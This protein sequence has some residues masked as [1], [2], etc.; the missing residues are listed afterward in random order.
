MIINDIFSKRQSIEKY[1]IQE[2]SN[3]MKNDQIKLREVSKIHVRAIKKYI[4][5]NVLSEQVYFPPIVA[6]AAFLG[7]DKPIDLTIIDGSQRLK[8]FYQ[9][10]EMGYRYIKSENEDE[11]KKGYKILHFIHY[12]EIVIQLFEGLSEK[13]CNQLFIDL[14]TKGKK[15]AL[16]KR[17]SFDSRKELNIITNNILKSNKQLRIAGVEIEKTAVIRPSNKKLLSLSQLR[18]VVAIFL[19]GK[20][21][22]RAKDDHYE[23]F[24]KAEDYIHLINGWFQELFQLYS[25]EKIGDLNE[26]ML[27]NIPLLLSIAYYANKGLEKTSFDERTQE[28]NHRMRHLKAVDFNSFCPN[29]RRFKGTERAGHFYFSNDKKNIESIVE[30]LEQQWEVR[31]M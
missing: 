25:P 19:T 30:W 26:S 31:V 22:Y 16:S 3:L 7:K 12:T 2:L 27:A 17:I 11:M 18:Q 14:N 15:V 8:A 23:T 29:W 10:E 4:I 6:N 28:M 5:E 1:T 20:M 9:L 21:N 24:L 13:E